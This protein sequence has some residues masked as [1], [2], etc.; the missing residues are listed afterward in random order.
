LSAQ[1]TEEWR[2]RALIFDPF[3]GISGDMIL[4][5]LVDLGLPAD[6]LDGFVASLR[7]D[8]VRVVSGRAQRRGIDCGRV[9]FEIPPQQAHR[10]LQ[11]IL[12]LVEGTSATPRVKDR[13]AAAFRRLAEAEAKVH[14][15]TPERV[16][17]HEVGALDAILDVLCTVAGLEQLGVERCYT[18]AVAVGQGSVPMEH[19]RYPLPAPATLE[20]L[21]G[22]PLREDGLEGECTTPTG[23]ALL[24]TLCESGAA[25][26]EFVLLRA[27]YGAGTRDPADRP[28]C[29]R[30]LLVQLA[31]GTAARTRMMVLQADLDDMPPEYLPDAQA[32]LLAAGAVDA[33]A[34]PL[35]MKKG[36]VGVRLEALVPEGTLDRVLSVLFRET[37]TIG[38]RYWPVERPALARAEDSVEWRGQ[39]VRRKRVRLPDGSE[40]AKPEHDDVV[41]AARAAGVSPLEAWR[42]LE[43]GRGGSA[44]GPAPIRDGTDATSAGPPV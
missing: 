29:L 38:A 30:A 31:D 15:T 35:G 24:A 37:S 25:P 23:A 13:A 34:V 19:G 22:L 42:E 9:S 5:A 33:V 10:H 36:R 39:Q 6:W 32:A 1:H 12:Q 26:G 14:G 44:A 17:F 20:L 21:A 2:L 11:Q 8:G 3:A 7:L 43:A 16:H 4:G 18:R 27:G 40:R 41:R 28:N